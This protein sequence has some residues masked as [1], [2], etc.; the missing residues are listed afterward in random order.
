MHNRFWHPILFLPS[1][2]LLA[3]A[4]SPATREPWSNHHAVFGSENY[5]LTVVYQGNPDG[6]LAP[7]SAE[8]PFSGA[9]ATPQGEFPVRGVRRKNGNGFT[10][11]LVT[12]AG[13]F[14]AQS[15]GHTPCPHDLVLTP[16]AGLQLP[17]EV[18]RSGLCL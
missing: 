3:A 13:N 1:F 18:L 8:I 11:R 6:I 17:S 7:E 9:L 4:G 16:D 10:Y 5:Y 15:T 14:L 2:F 12:R